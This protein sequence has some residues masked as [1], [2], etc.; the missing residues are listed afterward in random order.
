MSIKNAI[1]KLGANAHKK[2]KEEDEVILKRSDAYI[3]VL[4][5]DLITKGTKEPYRMFTSRAEYRLLLRQDN[6]DIRLTPKGY[7]IGLASQERM[8][9]VKEKIK[10]TNEL[11]S[12]FKTTS[13][14]HDSINE[15][16]K[17]KDSSLLKQKVKFEKII[18]RPNISIND[19]Y[20]TSE[21]ITKKIK[22]LFKGGSAK[23]AK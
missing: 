14:N 13:V 17:A 6:A 8:D 2:L 23:A 9:R 22:R 7:E 15:I 18:T 16:L 20:H 11:I 5:D 10:E 4:I 1:I 19:I 21:K 3:G 12:L